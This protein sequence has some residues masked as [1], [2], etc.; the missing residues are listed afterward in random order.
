MMLLSRKKKIDCINTM[1]KSKRGQFLQTFLSV[2]KLPLSDITAKMNNLFCLFR[3]CCLVEF[4]LAR[5]GFRV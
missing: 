5:I 1:A 2:C 3:N 4:R